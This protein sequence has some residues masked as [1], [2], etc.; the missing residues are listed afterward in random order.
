MRP[1]EFWRTNNGI[2]RLLDPIG[3]IVG[4]ITTQRVR[5]TAALRASVPVISVGN[6][7][8]G[9]TGKTPIAMDIAARLKARGTSPAVILRGYGGKLAGPVAV[10]VNIHTVDDVG[11]EALLHAAR[12]PTW[13]ARSRAAGAVAATAAGAT[14]LVLDDAHQHPGIV[15]DLSLVAI[16][17][18]AGFGNGRIVPAGPL[19][20]SV[21]DGLA[22]ADAVVIV[23]E[24]RRNIAARLPYQFPILRAALVPGPEREALRGRKVVAFAGIGDPE[25]FFH[26]LRALGAQVVATHPFDDHHGFGEAD[27]Q[28]IL[29]EAFSLQAIP[30]TTAKDAVRLP[31]DQRQQVNV[32]SVAVEWSDPA[33]LDALLRKF[34]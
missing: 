32:L 17:G 30:V 7:T 34:A 13:V 16:D 1:P 26:T 24:D 23:N 15:K 10:D 6:L 2:A 11:D 21:A 31:P 8:V 3:R 25:K 27:I 29:D 12:G 14:V 28:P 18:T 33:A 22:R 20:E 9:G 19:R 4:H 5:E